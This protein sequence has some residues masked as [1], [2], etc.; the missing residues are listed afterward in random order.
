MH[1][2]PNTVRITAKRLCQK[3]FMTLKNVKTDFTQGHHTNC[4][5]HCDGVLQE[6]IVLNSQCKK[7][8]KYTAKKQVENE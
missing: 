7:K 1:T 8:M 6:R 3:L 4:R 2:Y 5:N